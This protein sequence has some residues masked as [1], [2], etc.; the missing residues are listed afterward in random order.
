[1]KEL[2]ALIQRVSTQEAVAIFRT[3]IMQVLREIHLEYEQRLE[4]AKADIHSAYMSKMRI[5]C[6]T[7]LTGPGEGE[8]SDTYLRY[9]LDEQ[10]R[11]INA[12]EEVVSAKPAC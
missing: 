5:L 9:L 4:A 7:G 2:S 12:L 1:M 11:K 6:Q 10:K 3:E 8:I